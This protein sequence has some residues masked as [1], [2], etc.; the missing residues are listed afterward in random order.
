MNIEI[1]S[2]PHKSH[3]YPTLGDYLIDKDKIKIFVSQELKPLHQQLVVIH[4]LIE[5]LLCQQRN[6]SFTDIDNFDIEFEK[7]YPNNTDEPGEQEDAPYRKEHLFAEYIETQLAK[8]FNID[9]NEYKLD[10]ENVINGI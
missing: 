7:K 9:M 10:C 5:L 4:E 1:T 8:E 2:I 6:I 3:R